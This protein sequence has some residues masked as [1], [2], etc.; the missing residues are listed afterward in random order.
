[1]HWC[2]DSTTWLLCIYWGF[3]LNMAETCLRENKQLLIW[4]LVCTF[5]DLFIYLTDTLSIIWDC[6]YQTTRHYV[7]ES[8]S[9]VAN[10]V[11]DM[12]YRSGNYEYIRRQFIWQ[13]AATF[14]LWV[15]R[16]GRPLLVCRESGPTHISLMHLTCVR[17]GLYTPFS[18]INRLQPNLHGL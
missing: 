14:T 1:M 7:S 11:R 4:K 17:L 9:S 2:R 10:T 15:S 6:F 13:L 5:Y 18:F 12:F 3:S 16:E 8:H